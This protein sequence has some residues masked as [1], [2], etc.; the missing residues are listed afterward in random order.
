M[1][2]IKRLKAIRDVVKATPAHLLDMHKFSL[3]LLATA[4]RPRDFCGCAMHHYQAAAGVRVSSLLWSKY[5]RMD[6]GDVD[7]IFDTNF[8]AKEQYLTWSGQPAKT[9]FLR[10]I[11]AFIRKHSG[12]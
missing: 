6:S 12:E 2:N 7:R 3:N 10:R 8:M 1:P 9:L 4:S 11:N 5:L